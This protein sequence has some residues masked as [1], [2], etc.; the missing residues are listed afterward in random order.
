MI[1]SLSCLVTLKKVKMQNTS[2][3]QAL[4]LCGIEPRV[5][6]AD[7]KQAHSLFGYAGSHT[8][9]LHRGKIPYS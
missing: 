8:L 5:C 3:T 2:G 9:S 1:L 7:Y 6:C 4:T